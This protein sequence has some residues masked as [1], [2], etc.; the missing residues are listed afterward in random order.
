[1]VSSRSIIVDSSGSRN[2][3][4]S[5]LP[6]TYTYNGDGT[7]ATDSVTDGTLTWVKT[8][9]YTSG[10]LTSETAWVKQ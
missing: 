8:Y 4:V 1:M 9:G 2:V 6:H 10:K 5:S 7:L 3:D